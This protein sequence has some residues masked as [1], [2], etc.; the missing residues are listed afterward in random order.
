M[1]S[2][3]LL[4]SLIGTILEFYNVA[5]YATFAPLIALYYFPPAHSRDLALLTYALSFLMRPLGAIVFGYI[6]DKY[7]RKKA[8]AL[9]L[10]LMGLFSLLT[11]L[12][13]TYHEIGI[14]ASILIIAARIGQGF[15]L[16]ASFGGALVVSLEPA[17]KNN[18]IIAGLLGSSVLLGYLSANIVSFV[19][20]LPVFSPVLWKMAF[21]IGS[22]ISIIG[23]GI[24][25]NLKENPNFISPKLP[26]TPLAS[27]LTHHRLS[28]FKAAAASG[29]IGLLG[30]FV[31]VY[32]NFLLVNHLQ[33]TLTQSLL[34]ISIAHLLAIFLSP[35]GGLLG[36]KYS[37]LRIIKL[38][39]LA[40]II[41][42]IPCLYLI[43]T[44]NIYSIIAAV[45]LL[46][47]IIGLAGGNSGLLLYHLFPTSVRYTGITFSDSIGKII[48]SAFIP[49]LCH[50]YTSA[51][52]YLS[53]G[54]IPT[55]LT[56]VILMLFYL[57]FSSFLEKKK[58]NSNMEG[59]FYKAT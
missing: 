50:Y 2:T 34:L 16:G 18:G 47:A 1:P 27:V 42:I 22:L 33:W 46:S 53:S 7:T 51:N 45:F 15:S 8:F 20:T 10:I 3:I 12:I 32:I 49:W 13:P 9:P 29:L 37:P 59:S 19:L 25:F 57:P 14:T 11:F 39:A 30:S 54:L 35:L 40:T 31:F 21:M 6:G 52:N 4:A 17:Q 58:E 24:Q 5:L 41:T 44:H 43:Q 28:V 55:I 36:Q 26:T 38:C 56:L 48:F 23:I